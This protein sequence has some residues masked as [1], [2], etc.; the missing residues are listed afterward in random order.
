MDLNRPILRTTGL[1]LCVSAAEYWAPAWTRSS[2]IEKVNIKL[3]KTMRIISGCLKST[4]VPL[5]T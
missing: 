3:R 2:L 5:S 4:P 1:S